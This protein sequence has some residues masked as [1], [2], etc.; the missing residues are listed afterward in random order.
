MTKAASCKTDKNGL[1]GAIGLR[2]SNGISQILQRL[3]DKTVLLQESETMQFYEEGS[4]IE[5][6]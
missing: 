5:K 3:V 2:V 6:K 4:H 1:V